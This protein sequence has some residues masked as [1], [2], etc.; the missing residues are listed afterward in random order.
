M[1]SALHDAHGSV[2]HRLEQTNDILGIDLR[3]IMFE[4]PKEEL[5]KTLNTQP[6]LY[7]L[8]VAC[9]ELIT[10]P[11]V[12][13]AATAGHSLGEYAACVVAGALSFED[14]LRLTRLRGEL[15]FGAGTDRPGAMA[16]VMGLTEQQVKP[17]LESIEGTVVAANINATTQ[18]VISGDVDAVEASIEPLKAA[19]A[20]RAMRLPVSGAFH[21]P[22]MEPASEGLREA[23][24]AVT[25][26]D[27][28]IPVVSNVSAEPVTSADAIR[29]SLVRQ[30]MAPVLW[31]ASM[32][33]LLD[34]GH[35]RFVEVGPGKVLQGLLRKADAGAVAAGVESPETLSA[36][37]NLAEEQ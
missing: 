10:S 26:K 33:T 19:G 16:A 30:L 11:G 25:F 15:M 5:T 1:G 31:E 2:R 36:F 14:G 13:F 12:T 8:D 35:T 21:S 29:D 24:E 6:A 9:A 37:L 20:R 28:R 32:R 17:V 18:I 23:L 34:A 22:L 3:S 7:A 27:A 4:G